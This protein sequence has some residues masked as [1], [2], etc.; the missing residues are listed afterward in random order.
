MWMRLSTGKLAITDK[1]N[2][3]VLG[4]HFEKVFNN[5]RL[6]EWNMIDKIKQR[7]TMYESNEPIS[8]AELKTG[9]VKLA[10]EKSTRSQQGATKC[11]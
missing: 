4:P 8:W 5:H 2:A 6:I 11:H 10:N 3:E 1:E 7:Q 9:I